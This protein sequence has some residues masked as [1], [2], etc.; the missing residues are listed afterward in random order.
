MSQFRL[1]E[2]VYAPIHDG[3]NRT[4]VRPVVIIE[5]EPDHSGEIMVIAISTKCQNPCPYYHIQVKHGDTKDKYTGLWEPSWAKC[6]FVRFP[7]V[8]R[9]KSIIGDMPT[10]LLKQILDVH[11]RIA[12]L[13]DRFCDWQ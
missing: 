7:K 8:S 3:K 11:D 6:N 12:N 5:N 4:K 10:K 9:I 13:G 1:G 2:I